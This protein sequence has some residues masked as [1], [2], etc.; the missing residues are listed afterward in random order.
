MEK[1]KAVFP[2]LREIDAVFSREESQRHT[3]QLNRTKSTVA[4]IDTTAFS[5]VTV[6]YDFRTALHHD[7]GD[8]KDGFGCLSVLHSPNDPAV[9][10]ELIFPEFGVAIRM[11][12]S[13]VLLFDSHQWHCNAPLATDGTHRMSLVCYL[14]EAMLNK[15]Q[16]EHIAEPETVTAL[17][18]RKRE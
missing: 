12:S 3:L 8:F 15:C 4:Q 14:R 11:T 13:D 16:K 6:N 2:L 1:Y 10:G 17:K 9:G 7:I 18:K 5:T